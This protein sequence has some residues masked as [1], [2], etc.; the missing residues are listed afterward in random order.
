MSS[1]M[2]PPTVN[3]TWG[4][5]EAPIIKAPQGA[6][7]DN[8]KILSESEAKKGEAVEAERLGKYYKRRAGEL[9]AKG[10]K[11]LGI[12]IIL[13]ISILLFFWYYSA[14]YMREVNHLELLLGANGALNQTA[15]L[16]SYYVG[17]L[18]GLTLLTSALIWCA[19]IYSHLR[20]LKI[21]YRDKEVS[22]NSYYS[23]MTQDSD[24]REDVRKYALEHLFS[25][26]LQ[27]IEEDK[28]GKAESIDISTLKMFLEWQASLMKKT[29]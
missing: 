22:A 14:Y 24:S 1:A 12:G 11:W 20:R 16:T 23:F 10:R 15:I 8:E 21:T 5:L 9:E 13:I 29:E 17:K 2:P 19:R 26:T 6:E 18:L 28:K 7:S 4:K 27:Q 25:P 3:S